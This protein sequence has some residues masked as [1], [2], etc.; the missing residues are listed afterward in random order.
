MIP[1]DLQRIIDSEKA[2]NFPAALATVVQ[3][4]DKHYPRKQRFIRSLKGQGRRDNRCAWISNTTHQESREFQKALSKV[5]IPGHRVCRLGRGPRA[6]WGAVKYN[7]Y[8]PLPLAETV[9]IYVYPRY[10]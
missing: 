5:L 6:I 9:S 8:L 10:T 7:S 3:I 4:Y 2:A 1:T